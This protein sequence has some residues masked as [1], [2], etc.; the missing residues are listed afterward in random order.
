MQA[1]KKNDSTSF[2]FYDAHDLNNLMPSVLS[3]KFQ[4]PNIGY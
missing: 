4:S 3:K 2:N 1:W